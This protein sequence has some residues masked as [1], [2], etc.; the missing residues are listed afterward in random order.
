MPKQHLL[1]SHLTPSQPQAAAFAMSHANLTL[2]FD[3]TTQE[4]LHVNE[5]HLTSAD[6]PCVVAVNLL[7]G[8]TSEDY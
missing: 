2:G 4:K 3:A 5:I 7:P 1:E 6:A 8:G